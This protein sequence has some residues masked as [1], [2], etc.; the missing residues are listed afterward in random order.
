[1]PKWAADYSLAAEITQPLIN[2]VLDKFLAALQAN[3]KYSASFGIGS[4]D[5][6]VKDLQILDLT[7]PAPIG[8]VVT[9]LRAKAEFK[10]RLFGLNI[11]NTNMFFQIDDIEI[12]FATTP[13]GM[14]KGIVLRALPTMNISI[15]F[16]NTRFI[17][18]WLLNRVIAPLVT[19]GI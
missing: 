8:G 3:L 11:I 17:I 9:D 14:P 19:F 7:D 15:S 1:M 5:A 2:L 18:R 10:L 16:P 6:E 12:D 13:A 4:F